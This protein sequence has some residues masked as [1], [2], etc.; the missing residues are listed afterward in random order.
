MQGGCFPAS[1]P[2]PPGLMM[3]PSD[4]A[5]RSLVRMDWQGSAKLCIP[6]AMP[7]CLA[8]I[9][10]RLPISGP[11][12]MQLPFSTSRHPQEQNLQSST[13]DIWVEF[14]SL[15]CRAL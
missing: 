7:A 9:P 4:W 13:A 1:D 14:P 3:E 15:T 12:S 6:P 8:P 11:L 5:G 10:T 2:G